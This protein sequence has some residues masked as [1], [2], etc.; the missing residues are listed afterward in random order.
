MIPMHKVTRRVLIA[1]LAGIACV[2]STATQAAAVGL[3]S[4][5]ADPVVLTGSKLSSLSG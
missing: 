5:P 1:A 3:Q 4:R 2:M